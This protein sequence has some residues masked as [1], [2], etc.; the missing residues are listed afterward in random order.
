M[1]MSTHTKNYATVQRLYIYRRGDTDQC[2]ITRTKDHASL[3]HAAPDEWRFWMQIGCL[4]AK[5]GQYGFDVKAIVNDIANQGHSLF[6]G[7]P[8]L[9]D[10]RFSPKEPSSAR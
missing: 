10:L 2:A 1:S 5:T 3:P 6:S 8:R 9:L 7:S 4:Q